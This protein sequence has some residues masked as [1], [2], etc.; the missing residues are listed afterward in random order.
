MSF[1]W[2]QEHEEEHNDAFRATFG[3][4]YDKYVLLFVATANEHVASVLDMAY[5]VRADSVIAIDEATSK[6]EYSHTVPPE[7]MRS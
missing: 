4:C 3:K 5:P 6:G 2:E 1:G 7:T